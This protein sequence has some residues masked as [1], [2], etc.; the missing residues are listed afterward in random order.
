MNKQYALEILGMAECKTLA[1]NSPLLK[2]AIRYLERLKKIDNDT[3]QRIEN[4]RNKQR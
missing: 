2:E 3:M 4:I 1:I